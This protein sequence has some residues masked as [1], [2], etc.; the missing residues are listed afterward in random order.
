MS[1]T[2]TTT[3]TALRPRLGIDIPPDTDVD[4]YSL[5]QCELEGST[6]GLCRRISFDP[7][8]LL[9]VC[10]CVCAVEQDCSQREIQA[11]WNKLVCFF[12]S[13]FHAF[14]FFFCLSLPSHA[15]RRGRG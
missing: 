2:T 14:P 12:L 5:L 11:A 3:V 9:W 4:Y 8:S 6:D 10:V 1:S 15:T 7:S 13:C